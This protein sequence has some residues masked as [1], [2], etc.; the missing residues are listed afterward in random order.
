MKKGDID[1]PKILLIIL[2]LITLIIVGIFVYTTFFSKDYSSKH[3]TLAEQKVD[4]TAAMQ[5]Q[6]ND[7]FKSKEF[8]SAAILLLMNEIKAY[9]LHAS[10]FSGNL[11]KIE[12]K[13]DDLLFGIT[14]TK[15][16]FLIEA[17]QTDNADIEI[18][19]TVEELKK[20]VLAEDSKAT[21]I[22]SFKSGNS[23]I[24]LLSSKA[25]LMMK[26]YLDL[27]EE[28]YG[29]GITGSVIRMFS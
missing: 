5:N 2:I 11:P 29:T 21:V 16:D 19:T 7:Y 8:I 24:E 10:A 20:F 22:E 18:I 9:N 17:G 4:L 6:T 13:I 25:T 23:E 3:N 1:L 27:Y 26:G 12:L 15:G 28:V 14:V